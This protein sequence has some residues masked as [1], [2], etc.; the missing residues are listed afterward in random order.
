MMG[1][2]HE[3]NVYTIFLLKGLNNALCLL[4]SQQAFG[5]SQLCHSLGTNLR[6]DATLFAA[7]QRQLTYSYWHCN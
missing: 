5:I 1:D 4:K 3:D 2:V 7:F 6:N